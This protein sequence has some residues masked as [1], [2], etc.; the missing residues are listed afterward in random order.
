MN[1]VG[2]F[3]A[4]DVFVVQAMEAH[5]FALSVILSSLLS[6]LSVLRVF[7][8]FTYLFSD[9]FCHP[10]KKLTPLLNLYFLIA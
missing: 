10:L 1:P 2:F 3:L 5:A 9:W 4:V 7:N 6:S 8:L